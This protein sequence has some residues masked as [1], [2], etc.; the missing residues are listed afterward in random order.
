MPNPPLLTLSD[1]TLTWG[2]D[3][4]F[5]GVSCAI[6]RGDRLALVGRNGSGKSTL[7]KIM[8]GLVAPDGGERFVQPGARVAYLEQD[9]DL[10]A[11]ETLGAAAAAA[12]V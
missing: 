9:P 2:G 6:G 7:L 5:T 12:S 11:H 3:P 4:L 10:S 8:S 1:I